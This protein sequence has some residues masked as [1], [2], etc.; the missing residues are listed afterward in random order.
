[1]DRK[2]SSAHKAGPREKLYKKD[3]NGY[4][5]VKVP[6]NPILLSLL[7]YFNPLSVEDRPD[8]QRYQEVKEVFDKL[9]SGNSYV[10]DFV[11]LIAAAPELLEACKLA[12]AGIEANIEQLPA[13]NPLTIANAAL[14][15][16][17]TQVISKSEGRA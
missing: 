11:R 12:K 13:H 10:P 3:K 16:L 8:I 2:T 5:T 4:V 1:M 6:F 14:M 15:D 17:L 7:G 9:I